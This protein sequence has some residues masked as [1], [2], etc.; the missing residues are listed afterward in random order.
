MEAVLT[1]EH[2]A[3]VL[4]LVKEPIIV[5]PF[6][7]CM[8]LSPLCHKRRG[9]TVLYPRVLEPAVPQAVLMGASVSPLKLKKKPNPEGTPGFSLLLIR[10]G[11]VLAALTVSRLGSVSGTVTCR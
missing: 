6:H 4:N 1:A 7:S 2:L 3:M 9:H 5:F 11:A 10:F 8:S